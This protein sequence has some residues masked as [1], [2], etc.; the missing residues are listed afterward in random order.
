[1][2][3]GFYFWLANCHFGSDKILLLIIIEFRYILIILYIY[4]TIN[5]IET[6]FCHISKEIVNIAYIMHCNK[7]Y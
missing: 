2:Q 3:F 5:N 7:N 6:L 1:M 4:Q